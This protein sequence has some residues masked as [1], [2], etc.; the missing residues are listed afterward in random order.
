MN[1][2]KPAQGL[3]KFAPIAYAV[4]VFVSAFLLFQVQPLLSKFILPW[5][6]GTPAVWTSAMLFFQIVLFLGYLY[7]HVTSVYLKP[8]HRL[9]LHLLVLAL[10]LA[11]VLVNRLIPPVFL[12]PT[13][14]ENE[15]PLAQVLLLLGATV[16]LPYFALSSTGP[17]LQKWYSE[18]FDKSPYRLFA[19]SNFGSLLAL[20]SYPFFF[21]ANWGI[22]S[23]AGMWSLGFVVFALCCGYC[24]WQTVVLSDHSQPIV[25]KPAD[26]A[27]QVALDSGS[28]S[29][30][31]MFGWIALPT[32]ACILFLAVTNEVCQNIATVPLL[33]IVPLA[34][35][36]LSFIVAFDQPKWYSRSIYATLT[37]CLIFILSNYTEFVYLASDVL[38]SIAGLDGEDQIL[39]S[40]LW[41]LEAGLYFCAL[42]C[43]LVVCH[44]EL[45]RSKPSPL[46]LTRFYLTLSLGGAVGGILVNL[47]APYVFDTFFELP[48]GLLCCSLLCGVLLYYWQREKP[49]SASS[50]TIRLATLALGTL[51]AFGSC[52][53]LVRDTM[54]KQQTAERSV[55]HRSRNF[56]GVLSVERHDQN[57][58]DDMHIFYSGN[59]QHGM[60]FT[61]P[62]KRRTPVGYYGSDSGCQK[63]IRFA[64][65][66]N[67][68]CHIGVI[69]LG[70]G[71]IS[72]YA[73]PEDKIR[74]YEINPQVIQVAKNTQWFQYLSDCQGQV[75]LVLG[76]ARLKL[77]SEL[78]SGHSQQF[79]VL[80]LDAFSGDAIPTHLLT[81]EAFALY[82][83]HLK[84]A[85]VLILHITNTHLDLYPV[86][87][88]LAK[89]HQ[90]PYRRIYRDSTEL[91]N[92][93]YYMVLCKDPKFQE[94]IAD[95]LTELP[96]YLKRERTVPLWTDEYTNLTRLLR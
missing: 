54:P 85:G 12:R 16:G 70:V 74:F 71:T 94:K 77:E 79:D 6:G 39:L 19:L 90:Y 9:Y 81:D 42:F 65:E 34:L 60:Q 41:W 48:L 58:P 57:T 2:G 55:V 67:P 37:L 75:D 84:P 61:D 68:K 38:N 59:I 56:Y 80:I 91:L 13:G 72:A 62:L 47:I 82:S 73:R 17:L 28:P 63:G 31:Q 96:E 93:N 44:G 51:L 83:Q 20:L 26:I 22:V 88:Q 46:Y 11:S 18:S 66:E 8:T 10:A 92:R 64:Q 87:K 69:G 4:T 32:I 53:Y 89:K 52:Y 5:F 25:D 27:S 3:P 35:Y 43:M 49:S 23:Q 36:L 45:A 86:A 24:A 15:S 76:D 30:V 95:D 1:E 78:K 29:L 7:A 40:K 50:K 21:E 14:A 33:W